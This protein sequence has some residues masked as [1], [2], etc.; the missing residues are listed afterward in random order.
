MPS[1][2]GGKSR[3]RKDIYKCITE[4]VPEESK[5][6]YDLFCGG[7]NVSLEFVGSYNVYC[8]DVN[9]EVIYLWEY[10]SKN[11]ISTEIEPVSKEEYNIIRKSTEKTFKNIVSKYCC[12]YNARYG[13]TYAGND[14]KRNH[15]Q[16]TYNGILKVVNK[17]KLVKS[18]TS[19]SYDCFDFSKGGNIIY[20]DPPYVGTKQYNK[21]LD[22][23]FNTCQ[24]W[25]QVK[26][27][28]DQGNYVFVSE[29]TCPIKHKLLHS[30]ELHIY[31]TK[32]KDGKY[33]KMVDNLYMVI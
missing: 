8:N 18:F 2:H 29:K 5:N 1:Y 31:T 23:V 15:H 9:D 19:T 17:I 6:F 14:V 28:A 7:L 32:N 25:K 3:T 12:S 11:E 16:G 22:K 30:K 20:C 27:W 21:Q 4:N 10:V 13:G 24:F 26:I 33:G